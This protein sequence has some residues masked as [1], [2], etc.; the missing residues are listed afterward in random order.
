L[1]DKIR[2]FFRLRAA[3][4]GPDPTAPAVRKRHGEARA[5][6]GAIVAESAAGARL[7]PAH[8]LV[9]AG[10]AKGLVSLNLAVY[11]SAARPEKL[12]YELPTLALINCK[13]RS[14]KKLDMCLDRLTPVRLVK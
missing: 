2:E 13:L 7:A 4:F 6:V 8:G 10:L 9:V 3:R 1:W 14:R 11:R 12:D 5:G